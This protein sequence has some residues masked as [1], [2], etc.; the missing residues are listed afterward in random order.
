VDAL[1]RI[2][3]SLALAVAVVPLLS[4][5]DGGPPIGPMDADPDALFGGCPR[6]LGPI[7]APGDPIDGDDYDS[8]A[9]PFFQ[10]WCTRCHSTT[11]VTPEDRMNAPPG[12]NWDDEES[13]RAHLSLIRFWVGE[14][15]AMPINDPKPTCEERRRLVRWID[16]GAP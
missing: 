10:M 16:A 1:T 2:I 11:R 3:G 14:I 13:I 7:A 5:G 4:C 8:F 12:R 6:L 9:A 15:N